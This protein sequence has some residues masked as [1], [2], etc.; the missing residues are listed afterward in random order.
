MENKEESSVPEPVPPI[1]PSSRTEEQ[2][3]IL[4]QKE[5]KLGALG[6]S[7]SLISHIEVGDLRLWSRSGEGV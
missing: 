6:R 7:E 3:L 1:E 5:E 4:E 2:W